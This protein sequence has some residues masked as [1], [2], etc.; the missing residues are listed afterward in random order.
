MNSTENLILRYDHS[1]SEWVEALPLGNGRIGAMVFGGETRERYQLNEGTVW[2]GSP[3]D[4]NSPEALDALPEI[5]RLIFAGQIEAAQRLV[6]ETFMGRP[7]GQMPYQT[8]GDLHLDF[9]HVA[10]SHFNRALDLRSATSTVSYR[11]GEVE[12]VRESWISAP[13]QLL[14]VRI[15]A[16]EPGQVSFGAYF[17]SP[18]EVTCSAS[19]ER[20]ILEGKSG[21][22]N[23]LK[24]QNR[25]IAVLEANLTGGQR[26]TSA[27]RIE[28]RGADA[29][30][31]RL[32][33][34]TNFVDFSDLSGNAQARAHAPLE[35]AKDVEYSELQGRHIADY[36]TLFDRV[37][38]DLGE[39]KL[40]GQTTPERIQAF[41]RDE[42]P[43]LAALYFQYGRYLLISCSRPGGQPSTLQG[44]WNNSLNPPWQS[45][46]TV[47]INTEMNYWPVQSANLAECEAPLRGLIADL[48]VTGRQTAERQYGA[49]G[50]VCHHNTDLWRGT[51]PVDWAEPG[52]WPTGGAW[53]VLHLWESYRFTGDRDQ[54]RQDFP[55]LRGAAEFFLDALV[56]DPRNGWM[57]TCPSVSPENAH[58]AGQ[59]LCA[60]PA[61]DTQIIAALFDACLASAS[62]LDVAPEF[63][64]EV[65]TMRA[66][67][68]PMQIGGQ[69]QL[70]EWIE[71][72]DADA[73]EQDHRHVS[74]LWAL[75]PGDQ[76]QPETSPELFAA[77]RRSLELRGD[78][79]TGWSLAWKIN[80][81]A[82]LRDGD[83]ALAL[84]RRALMPVNF[85]PGQFSGGGGVYPNLF[86]AHPPFQ[87]DGNFGFTA[88]VVEMLVQSH[89]DE[90][91]L[92]P[93]LPTAWKSGAIR[94]IRARGNVEVELSWQDGGCRQVRLTSALAQ[95]IN[96]RYRDKIRSVS[97][98]AGETVMLDH[99]LAVLSG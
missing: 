82:R 3:H 10:P 33:L 70:Q 91:H 83:R 16:S 54:L 47:N 22:H 94:G 32:S 48:A 34:A 27:S 63:V 51:A 58:H 12:F 42:D 75:F 89:G 55:L 8:V 69:G 20:L 15:S 49:R 88:G 61:M 46:Y 44:L 86:D 90:I 79:G 60:G 93:A 2:G 36:R 29:V 25:F 13:D 85:E 99:D 78:A 53:L 38:L 87:I 37:A 43:A 40:L 26:E 68:A 50:W 64:L 28:I 98:S 14:V 84:I 97:F 41:H 77:A 35:A 96:V 18:Q 21:D 9:S 7:N 4:Y 66:R 39:P 72:W 5:R 11:V 56:E 74:H 59:N 19:D 73:P 17:S 57:V 76:I 95:V 92:L 1:A 67:L 52:M 45:K 71:D 81:W 6:N 65:R 23:G 31:L 30:E 24:G 80:L 62:L